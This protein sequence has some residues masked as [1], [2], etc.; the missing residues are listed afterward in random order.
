MKAHLVPEPELEFCGGRRHIDVRFGLLEHGPLDR[1]STGARE[2][3]RVGIVGDAEGAEQLALWIESCRRGVAAKPS[4]LRNLYPA[5]P[6]FGDHG[7]FCD[8][9]ADRA[10]RRTIPKGDLEDLAGRQPRRAAVVESAERYAREVSGLTESNALDVVVCVLPPTLLKRI[11]IRDP[12]EEL[13]YA[14]QRP[15]VWHDFLKAQCIGLRVPIQVVRPATFGGKVHRYRQDG[16]T[17]R[18]VQDEATR[19]WNFFCALYYKAGGVPWRLLR[20]AADHTT[21]YV[22]VSF[23][24]SADG[25]CLETSV[26]QVFNQRGEGVVVRGGAAQISKDDRTPHVADDEAAEL[27]TRA[28]ELYRGEHGNAPARIVLHKS[29]YFTPGERDGFKSAAR[30]LRVDRIDLASLRQGGPRYF[31]LRDYAPL[32]GTLVELSERELSLFTQGSVDF[33]RCYP[34]LFVPSPLQILLDDTDQGGRGVASEILSL[35]KMNWNSTTFVNSEPITLAGAR[36]V[37]SILRYL[38]ENHSLQA[39]YCF[40]M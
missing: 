24:R 37:G 34:G 11:D 40:Y 15:P 30:A 18:E 32:R 23:F 16:K 7:A 38:S 10:W 17:T 39:R 4:R 28:I 5:F 29:S 1:G 22:G 35:T 6:G 8:F 26:A 19:A 2:R 36:Q 20:E 27:L 21:C 12:G 3:V 13:R 33:Y 9:V 25:E 14:A 31:R